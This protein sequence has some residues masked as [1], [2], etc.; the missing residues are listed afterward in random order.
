MTSPTLQMVNAALALPDFDLMQ[1]LA[2]MSPLGR[3]TRKSEPPPRQAGVLVLLS[4]PPEALSVTLT[5]RTDKLAGHS[6]QMSFPGGKRDPLDES[7]VATALRETSEEL[8]M[9]VSPIE[10]L[11]PLTQIYIPPSHFDVYPWVGYMP[12]LPPLHPNPDEVASVILPRLD[13]L[14]E[15]ANKT[16]T[17][18]DTIAGLRNVPAYR[19]CDQLVWGATAIM[20]C[21]LELRLRRVA[22]D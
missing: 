9:D 15:P 18:L 10:I 1:A 2:L 7:F 17:E 12:V 20:L 4:G 11:G 5:R 14:F 21:E 16:T 13:D 6:G 3:L 22:S 8:G 19:L